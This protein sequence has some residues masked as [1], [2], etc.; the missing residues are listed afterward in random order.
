VSWVAMR[1]GLVR[2]PYI[3]V[4]WTLPAPVGAW[5]STGGDPHAVALQL[6]NLAL[7]LLIWWPFVRRYDR[8]LCTAEHCK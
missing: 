1:L 5:L 4:V 7:A 2:P 8:S 3:E 6:V